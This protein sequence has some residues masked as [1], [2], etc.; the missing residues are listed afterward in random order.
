MK[1]LE[2]RELAQ[3]NNFLSHVN[4]G[5]HE[6]T[7]Q[8]ENYSCTFIVRFAFATF[9]RLVV[10]SSFFIPFFSFHFGK[11]VGTLDEM[12]DA[13]GTFFTHSLSIIIL[14]AACSPPSLNTTMKQANSR[15][16]IRKTL[17]RLKPTWWKSSAR[18][19]TCTRRRRLDL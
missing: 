14:T 9:P 13:R 15:V 16:K 10:G 5:D 2:D 8:L 4:L 17:A 1:F 7:G 3:L 11:D 19:R 6:V 18:R 12:R